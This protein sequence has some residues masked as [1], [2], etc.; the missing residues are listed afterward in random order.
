MA[1]WRGQPYH[2]WFQ[3]FGPTY[4]GSKTAATFPGAKRRLAREKD[5][6]RTKQSSDELANNNE[7][8][9]GNL[10]K[11]GGQGVLNGAIPKPDD[12]E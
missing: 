9:R 3:I 4:D 5:M 8:P 12:D 7:V 1:S 6:S 2:S 11:S 10:A